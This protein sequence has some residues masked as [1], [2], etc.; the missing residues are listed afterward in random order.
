M[1]GIKAESRR[2]TLDRGVLLVK[3][4]VTFLVHRPAT[5]KK[6]SRTFVIIQMLDSRG[7]IRANISTGFTIV[8]TRKKKRKTRTDGRTAISHTTATLPAI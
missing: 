6:K 8:S 3:P 4:E 7:M 5:K 1:H 2:A